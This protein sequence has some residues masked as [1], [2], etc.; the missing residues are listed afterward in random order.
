MVPEFKEILVKSKPVPGDYDGRKKIHAQ[1]VFTLIYMLVDF[2]SPLRDMQEE[3]KLQEALRCS[4]LE[5]ADITEPVKQ[6]LGLYE[7]YQ[8]NS[9]RSLRTLKA[10][11]TSLNQLDNYFL[12]INFSA[13]DKKGELLHSAKEYLA[14]MSGVKKAYESYEEFEERVHN[15][16]TKTE[17]VRGEKTLGGKE[18]KRLTWDE[19]KR[20]ASES[21]EFKELATNLFGA[22]ITQIDQGD[23]A[24]AVDRLEAFV[25]LTGMPADNVPDDFDPDAENDDE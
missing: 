4:E 3:E 25:S 5:V 23:T 8:Q 20:P 1:R 14:N 2:K 16:L 19:G 24:E 12:T 21:V 18:G 7:W 11:R 17:T 15:E 13:K 10:M 6:A 22:G 9:A